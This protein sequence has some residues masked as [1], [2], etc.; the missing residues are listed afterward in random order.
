MKNFIVYDIN[1]GEIK[2]FGQCADCCFNEQIESSS[3]GIIESEFVENSYVENGLLVEFPKKPD[4]KYFYVFDYT[5]KSWVIDNQKAKYNA[6]SKRQK[7]LIDSDWTQL[8]DVPLDDKQAWAVYRQELRDI[9][10]Q[11]NFPNDIIWPTPPT[12]GA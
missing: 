1:T 8:P 3:E 9:T 5:T 6:L 11:P 4:N 2:K 12:Q 10:S 7:L